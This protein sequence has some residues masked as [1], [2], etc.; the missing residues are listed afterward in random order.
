MKNSAIAALFLLMFWN[1]SQGQDIVGTGWNDPV[2]SLRMVM[3]GMKSEASLDSSLIRQ[4]FAL[5]GEQNSKI[6]ILQKDRVTLVNRV[7]T[8]R[9]RIAEL[10]D[11]VRFRWEFVD[12]LFNQRAKMSDTSI[13]CNITDQLQ[14]FVLN[15][16][17]GKP[18]NDTP[19]SF[20]VGIIRM[21]P[22]DTIWP[23]KWPYQSEY[24]DTLEIYAGRD[25]AVIF[26]CRAINGGKVSPTVPARRK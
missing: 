18:Q 7:E 9:G 3:E 21:V 1:K 13:S 23:Q 11:S 22:V 25:T 16:K 8:M 15:W 10:S 5:E 19:D 17:P 14:K 6:A 12:S 24:Y 4:L 2:D 20:Q 26:V